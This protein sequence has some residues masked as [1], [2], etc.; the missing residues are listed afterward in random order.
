MANSIL[1]PFHSHC[2]IDFPYL[3]TEVCDG[4]TDGRKEPH[5]CFYNI[6]FKINCIKIYI[7]NLFV[8]PLKILI[9]KREVELFHCGPYSTAQTIKII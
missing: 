9:S 1:S 5:G 6:Y 3:I 7:K 8:L 4:Q 2:C